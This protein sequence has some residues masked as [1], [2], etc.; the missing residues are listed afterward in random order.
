MSQV[1]LSW[2]VGIV[3]LAYCLFTK[4]DNKWNILDWNIINL[5]NRESTKCA[6]NL[7]ASYTHNNIHYCKVCSRKCE[8]LKPF[9]ELFVEQN[10]DNKCNHLVKENI[11]GRKSLFISDNNYFCKTHAKSKYKNLETLYKVKPF[12]NKSIM[13][14]EYDDTRLKLFKILDDNKN[15]LEADI[16]LIENQ[17][18]MRNPTMK[19]ISNALYDY[20]LIRGLVDKDVTKSNIS[21]V[22]FMSPSN[23]LK[24]A[25]EDDTQKLIVAKNTDDA[26]GYK[27]TKQLSVKYTL[28]MIKHLPNWLEFINKQ[29]KKDDLCDAFLQGCYYFTKNELNN[30]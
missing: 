5:T 23:K 26:K 20:F 10:T 9:N 11:C 3:N 2:D 14:M 21:K 30:I 25:T 22:K 15:L 19:S 6:C 7:K 4:Q 29:K 17:P 13:S 27:L 18:S 16:V 12:K 28:E 24:L 8:K 1:I